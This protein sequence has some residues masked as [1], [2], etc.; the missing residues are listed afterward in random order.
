MEQ[1]ELKYGSAKQSAE[2]PFNVQTLGP[3]TV[4]AQDPQKLIRS[5]LQK[6]IGSPTLDQIIKPGE[7]VVIVTSDITRYTGS[8]IYLPILVEELNR[9]G[10]ADEQ[11]SILIA[12]GIH[13]EQTE[14][15]HKKILGPLYGRIAVFD[16]DCDDPEQLVNLGRTDSGFDVALNK[17]AIEA[18]RLIVTG[19]IGF[20]YFAGFGGGRKG[21]VPGV[22]SRETCMASHFAVF[23][24]PEIGGKHPQA[25]TGVLNGNPV[26]QALLQ[27]A[28]FAEPDFLLNTVLSPQ[29][30]LLAVYCG[31]L[32]QAH[33][34]GC[35]LVRDLFS[36]P[37]EQAADLAIISCGGE[38]KDINFIQSQKALDYGCRA[39]KEG[40]SI[41]LLASCRD[42]FGHPTFFDWFRYQDLDEFE[43]AL[44]ADYQINGQTAHAT[45][46]KARRFRVLLVSEF[47]DEETAKM[48]MQKVADLQ[49]AIDLVKADLPEEPNV[50]VIPDGGTVLPMVE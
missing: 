30:E 26:H 2:L 18:D 44:R 23:N 6:P 4:A 41:I 42:G 49:A 50:V 27:A 15:E 11:I 38:P 34:Q 45:L 9:I 28:R 47:S 1:L 39:V 25:V 16:H 37:L 32:E 21:L 14:E 31:D 46:H 7:S 36:V 35:E 29:K 19:T 8:E 10:V 13:R 3:K 43:T 12:L 17:R 22:A 33:L 20:H 5:A 40:G 24:P 48:G